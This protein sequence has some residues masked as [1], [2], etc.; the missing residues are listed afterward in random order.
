M[1]DM[2]INRKGNGGNEKELLDTVDRLYYRK[3][4]SNL[5]WETED[6]WEEILSTWE[7]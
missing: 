4:R 3:G 5:K 6:E 2:K 7:S 1:T